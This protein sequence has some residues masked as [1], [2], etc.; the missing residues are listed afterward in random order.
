MAKNSK[1]MDENMEN[2]KEELSET[3][4]NNNEQINKKLSLIHIFQGCESKIIMKVNREKIVRLWPN[5][6]VQ[7][8]C[9]TKV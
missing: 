2:L 6:H 7:K 4:E 3:I 1:K 5:W 9:N 8:L